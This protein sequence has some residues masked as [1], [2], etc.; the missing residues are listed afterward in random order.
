MGCNRNIL[1]LYVDK[2]MFGDGFETP[3][4]NFSKK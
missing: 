2:G 3:P 4:L 1:P